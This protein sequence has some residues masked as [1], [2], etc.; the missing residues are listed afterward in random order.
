MKFKLNIYIVKILFIFIFVVCSQVQAEN[1]TLKVGLY[2][3]VPRIEQFKN[4]IQAQWQIVQPNVDLVF[5]TDWDGGYDS[6]PPDDLD[7]FVFDAMLFENFRSNG[8]LEPME[9]S[10]ISNLDDFVSYAIKGVQY[11]GKYY[12]I[13]QLGCANILFYKKT[14]HALANAKSISELNS[15]LNQ[16]RYTSQVPPDVRGLMLDMKGGTTNATFYLDIA[17]SMNN[18]YPLPL[19]SKDE[20]NPDVIQ[21]MRSLLAMASYEN[22]TESP[23]K[24]YGRA[25]WFSDDY[26]RA[27][28]GYTEH[29]SA[30]SASTRSSIEFKPLPMTNNNNPPI[31]YAD[32]IAVNTK[33]KSRSLAVQLANV[34]ASKETMIASIGPDTTNRY[35]QY[36]MA[37]RP[38]VFTTLGKDFPI[39]NEMYSMLNSSNPIMFK[40]AANSREWLGNMKNV[41]REDARDQYACGCDQLAQSSI[42]NNSAAK[43]ICTPS[44]ARYGGWNGQWTNQPPAASSGRSVCG[45][46]TCT[47]Q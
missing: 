44:C 27:L 12:A 39:Y 41:I 16:C 36:L 8:F 30:M 43:S 42:P 6:S 21:G 1:T 40:L 18:I 15:V 46:K 28:I 17:H 33:S 31:Y 19:P 25:K 5:F 10:E 13:P 23:P 2:P 35:P 26:G 14:D 4:A 47:V 11:N 45:C 34:M 9:A 38:S 7:V 24:Q 20:L 37:T 3:Y 29:M 32:V 22:A